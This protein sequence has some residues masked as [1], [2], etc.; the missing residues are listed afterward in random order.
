MSAREGR[1]EESLMLDA[2]AEKRSREK[3][4]R[5]LAVIYQ[6]DECASF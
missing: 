1:T 5:T 4:I 2:H 3:Q 6:R